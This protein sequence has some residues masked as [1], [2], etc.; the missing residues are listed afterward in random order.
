MLWSNYKLKLVCV[1]VEYYTGTIIICIRQLC[2]AQIATVKRISQVGISAGRYT[3][4]LIYRGIV[5]LYKPVNRILTI[6]LVYL[7]CGH[8]YCANTKW[9][10]ELIAKPNCYNEV[11]YY[12]C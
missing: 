12:N 4:I 1:R 2:K 3:G 9:F 11:K 8:C 7:V 6:W 10:T 5:I